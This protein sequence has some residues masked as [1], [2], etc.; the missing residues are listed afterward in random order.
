MQFRAFIIMSYILATWSLDVAGEES[1]TDI[2]S[3]GGDGVNPAEDIVASEYLN[4]FT[5]VE[6]QGGGDDALGLDDLTFNI[7]SGGSEFILSDDGGSTCGSV[8]RKRDLIAD[9]VVL[10]RHC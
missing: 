10:S 2:F 8:S 5:N 7:A 6:I 3:D 9:G 1:L 4:D